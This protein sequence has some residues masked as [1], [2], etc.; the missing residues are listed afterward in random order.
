MITSHR[1]YAE[2]FVTSG[3]AQIL[4]LDKELNKLHYEKS[5]FTCA[6]II[7]ISFPFPLK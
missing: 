3:E 5:T 4:I 2:R 1:I 7:G 6:F